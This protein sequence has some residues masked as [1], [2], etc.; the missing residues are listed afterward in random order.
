[1]TELSYLAVIGDIR[2]SREVDDRAGVQAAMEKGLLALN[3]SLGDALGAGFVVTLGDEFQ[4]L[5]AD[6]GALMAVFTHMERSVPGVAFR[7]GVGWGPVSTEFREEALGMDGPCFHSARDALKLSK[8]A[9]RWATA[10]GFGGAEDDILT[11]MLWLLGSV[12]EGWSE[13]Q[14]A[15]VVLAREASTQREVASELGVAPSTVSEALSA[16]LYRPVVSAERALTL[17]LRKFGGLPYSNEN[18][19]E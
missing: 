9:D 4:G 10:R 5:L 1:M 2:A 13:K 15:T 16:A 8:D 19:E 18:S 7:Y 17:S 3:S 11:G 14:A 6:P 12:R